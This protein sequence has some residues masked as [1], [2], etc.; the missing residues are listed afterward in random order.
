MSKN[1]L[2]HQYK[3]DPN[4]L[5]GDTSDAYSSG[6]FTN[7]VEVVRVLARRGFFCSTQA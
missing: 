5:A 1:L 4:R 7:W 2:K 3:F 6:S